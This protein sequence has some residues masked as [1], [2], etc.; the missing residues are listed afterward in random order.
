MVPVTVQSLRSDEPLLAQVSQIAG[1]RIG[2]SAVVVSKVPRRDDTERADRREGAALRLAQGVSA[3]ARVVH[4]FPLGTAWQ[5][6]VPHE[7]VARIKPAGLVLAVGPSR[8]V[9]VAP[10]VAGIILSV[11]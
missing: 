1:P 8:L 5:I 3:L 11:V 7:H 10:T 4:E 2:W 9:A 6:E